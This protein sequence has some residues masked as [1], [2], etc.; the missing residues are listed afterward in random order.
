MAVSGRW[1]TSFGGCIAVGIVQTQVAR[2][3]GWSRQIKYWLVGSGL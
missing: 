3:M 2:C 1:G